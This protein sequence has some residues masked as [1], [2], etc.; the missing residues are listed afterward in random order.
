[1]KTPESGNIRKESNNR[2]ASTVGTRVEKQGCFQKY[3][4]CSVTSNI[5]QGPQQ[6]QQD[7]T[8]RKLAQLVGL[9]TAEIP[10][11][12]PASAGTLT[13]LEVPKTV[14]TPTTQHV[15]EKFAEKLL[16]TAKNS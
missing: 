2:T 11:T 13:A 3:C 8:T 9:A 6:Q 14:W 5:H 16:R 10:T 4:I 15:L 7:L 12:I 1:M